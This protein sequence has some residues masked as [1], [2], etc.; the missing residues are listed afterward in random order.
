MEVVLSKVVLN[1]D[2]NIFVERVFDKISHPTVYEIGKKL[3][4][5]HVVRVCVENTCFI[6]FEPI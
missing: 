5:V 2:Q 6:N 1:P 4:R 3:Y